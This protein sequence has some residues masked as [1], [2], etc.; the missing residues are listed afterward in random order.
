MSG[1]LAARCEGRNLA[2]LAAWQVAEKGRISEPR[3]S[4]GIPQGL[5][6]IHSIGFIGIR[7]GGKP[8]PEKKQ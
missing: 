6:P 7:R 3:G 1:F 8:C 2:R 5:K 4:Q